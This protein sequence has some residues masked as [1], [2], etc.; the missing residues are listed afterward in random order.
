MADCWGGRQHHRRNV[1][2]TLAIFELARFGCDLIDRRRPFRWKFFDKSIRKFEL[3]GVVGVGESF[4]PGC[5]FYARISSSIK[6]M[7]RSSIPPWSRIDRRNPNHRNERHQFIRKPSPHSHE[8]Q[9]IKF[10]LTRS[11]FLH[12]WSNPSISQLIDIGKQRWWPENK[13]F[14]SFAIAKKTFSSS[15]W[16]AQNGPVKTTYQYQWENVNKMKSRSFVL[17]I[18]VAPLVKRIIPSEKRHFDRMMLR[19]V[20][21]EWT[22]ERMSVWC[23]TADKNTISS[24][25]SVCQVCVC[26]CV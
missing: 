21:N 26:E 19:L 16:L 20:M 15:L 18:A 17:R 6:P 3:G 25:S 11:T 22:N 14:H 5:L 13:E 12:N 8:L 24:I 2:C 10:H 1:V 4:E 23:W 7:L 9:R